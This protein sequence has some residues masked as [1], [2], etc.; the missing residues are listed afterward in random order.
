MLRSSEYSINHT[1]LHIP[2]Y[3]VRFADLIHESPDKLYKWQLE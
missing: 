3:G 1:T 2:I